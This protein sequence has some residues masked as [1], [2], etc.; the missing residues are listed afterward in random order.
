M[1]IV[2]PTVGKNYAK[3]KG[4]IKNN[5]KSGSAYFYHLA[6]FSDPWHSAILLAPS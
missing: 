3:S 1:R 2:P 5:G 4:C 6:R